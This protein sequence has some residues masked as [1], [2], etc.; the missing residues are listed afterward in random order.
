[1]SAVPRKPLAEIRVAALAGLAS[2]MVFS[3]LVC[4]CGG[5]APEIALVEWRLELRP[6]KD[7]AY[8][9]LSAFASIR[10]DDG[11]EDIAELFLVNDAEAYAWPL[12]NADWTKRREG[13]DDWIG[14]AGFVRPDFGP[15]PR[16][17]YRIV[18]I[19]AAG[20]SVERA[21][22]VEGAFPS[23]AA[24]ELTYERGAASLR[25]SWPETLILG[26]DATGALVA[27]AAW[28]GK[29]ETL[30]D[31]YGEEPA[32]RVAEI[33]AYGYDPARRMGAYS[34]KRKTR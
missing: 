32:A 8:E 10:D 12:T 2:V 9:S 24:P 3:L 25:S 5:K 4:S 11:I 28:I 31:L 17:E 26:Y 20:E 27:Q 1:M 34:W 33:A 22:T 6:S 15:M 30:A 18:A 21:F 29:A 13:A 23:L 19:D 7:G 16:G 14:A